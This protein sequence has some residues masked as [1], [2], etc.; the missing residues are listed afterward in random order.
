MRRGTPGT[1]DTVT[2]T[3]DTKLPTVEAGDDRTVAPNI[4]VT[5]NGSGAS[6]NTSGSVTL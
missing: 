5:L 6:S 3:I 4:Q 1:A 2:I